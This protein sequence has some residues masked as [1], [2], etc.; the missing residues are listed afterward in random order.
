MSYKIGEHD[1]DV[2]KR[3]ALKFLAGGHRVKCVVQFRGREQQHMD[4]GGDLLLKLASDCE[5]VGVSGGRPKR[6]GNRLTMFLK[7]KSES[8]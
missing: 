2:R 3:S 7:P 4:L 8:S 6:E 5:E 1:Y